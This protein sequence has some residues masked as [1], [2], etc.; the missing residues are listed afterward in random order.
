MHAWTAGKQ[1]DSGIQWRRRKNNMHI[2]NNM[3]IHNNMHIQ[4]NMHIHNNMHNIHWVSEPAQAWLRSLPKYTGETHKKISFHEHALYPFT[5]SLSSTIRYAPSKVLKC[6][7]VTL[8]LWALHPSWAGAPFASLWPF[9]TYTKP[10]TTMWGPFTYV[11]PPGWGFWG[12]V[13]ALLGFK[14]KIHSR[15]QYNVWLLS[16][17]T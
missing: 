1:H 9:Y 2:R 13:P 11:W 5:T 3:H 4:H 7:K 6:L 17:S 16:Y 14:Y 10:F 12:S 8:H 15:N